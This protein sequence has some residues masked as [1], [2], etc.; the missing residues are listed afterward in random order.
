[1]RENGLLAP[2]RVGRT[3][4]KWH[5]EG[6]R[7]WEILSIIANAAA[8]LRHPLDDDVSAADATKA[9]RSAFEFKEEPESAIDPDIIP[10]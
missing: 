5:L 9:I 6:L 10:D 8:N 1:M 3:K 4:T 7:D 2:H